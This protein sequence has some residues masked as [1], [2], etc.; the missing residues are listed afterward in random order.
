MA[1]E[2]TLD[3]GLSSDNIITAKLKLFAGQRTV[4]QLTFYKYE[5]IIGKEH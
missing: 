5:Q 3:A 1:T 4:F 2:Y